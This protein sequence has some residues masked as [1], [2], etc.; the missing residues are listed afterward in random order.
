MTPFRRS[1]EI[2]AVHFLAK[3]G[4]DGVRAVRGVLKIAL[5]R[6]GMRAIRAEE[7]VMSYREKLDKMKEHGLYRV[8]DFDGGKEI[9]HIIDHL[10][11]DVKMFERKMDI[12][13]FKDTGR[14][15]QLN[16][17]N[18]ETLFDLFGEPE[19]WEG[20]QIALYLAPYG[21]NGKLGIRVKAVNGVTPPPSVPVVTPPPDLDD[22][23]PF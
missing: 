19:Q 13:N 4:T 16:Y 17:T 1:G 9:V 12:L 18:G 14:Q 22:E 11:Q 23:I 6:F 20:K 7:V 21:N 8:S 3:P 10:M 2:F 5:R 15:L